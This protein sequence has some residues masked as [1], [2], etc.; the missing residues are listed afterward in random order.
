MFLGL[1]RYRRMKINISSRRASPPPR[2]SPIK[3][4]GYCGDGMRTLPLDGGGLGGGD[5]RGRLDRRGVLALL[6]ALLVPAAARAEAPVPAR[7]TVQ[8]RA[9]LD[10][11]AA[12]LDG[13]RTIYARFQQVASNGSVASGQMWVERP[14]RMRFEYDPPSSIL[15]YADGWYV[16]YV[17]KALAEVTKVGLQSTP[18]WFLLRNRIAFDSDLIVTGF[19][20]GAEV[21]RVT[22][23]QKDRSDN[24]SLTMVFSDRPLALRQWTIVDQRGVSTT[25]T[26]NGAR[27]GMPL[28]AKLFT[29]ENPYAEKQNNEH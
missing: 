10:R 6:A 14:G 18:A 20:R 17:D 11:I 29:Y 15:L 1:D 9:D 21:M 5:A 26:L 25:V 22:V 2:P 13:I 12:Y 27:T 23:V 19:E 16:Y 28:D 7:L 24:G 8:D 4:E 3:G